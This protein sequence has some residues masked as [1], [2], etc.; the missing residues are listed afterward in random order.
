VVNWLRLRDPGFS[1]LRRACRSAILMPLLFAVGLHLLG[2]TQVAVFAAF[3]ALA[4]MML[5][6]FTGPMHERLQS[7]AGLAAGGAVMITLGTLTSADAWVAAAAML[8]VGFA[9]L[10]AGCVSSVLV[11]ASFALLL[12]FILPVCLPG[13]AGDIPARLGGWGM[14][15]AVAMVAIAVLWPAPENALLRDRVRRTCEA[16]AEC[17]ESEAAHLRDGPASASEAQR[18]ASFDR[19]GAAVSELQSFFLAT[20]TRPTDLTTQGRLLVRMVDE[21]AWLGAVLRTDQEPPSGGVADTV[22]AV[23]SAAAVV[24]ARSASLLAE[25]G[26]ATGELAAALGTLDA[27]QRQLEHAVL[28]E[29]PH[30]PRANR[31]TTALAPSFRTREVGYA[32]SLVG[33]NVTGVLL[34]ERRSWWE[35]LLGREPDG[36]LTPWGAARERAA[37]HWRRRSVW[38]HNSLRG[39]IA[40]ALAVWVANESGLQH[41]FWVVLGTLSVL[42]SNA[43]NTGQLVIR[44]IAG[45]ILGFVVGAVILIGVGTDTRALWAVLPVAVLGAGLAPAAIS[46]AAGQAGFTVTLVVLFNI[47]EPAGWKVGLVR[48]EDVAIGCAISLLVGLLFWPRGAAAALRQALADAYAVCAGY[49]DEAVECGLQ[50][51]AEHLPRPADGAGRAR[52]A[53]AARRLDDAFRTYLCERA[54]KPVPVAAVARLVSGVTALRV[55]GGALRELWRGG[56]A[57]PPGAAAA[58]DELRR[59]S[60]VLRDWYGALAQGISGPAAVPKPLDGDDAAA[61]RLVEA[62]HRQF[63]GNPSPDAPA[64]VHLIWTAD[65]LDALRRLQ[66]LLV[67]PARRASGVR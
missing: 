27:A 39:A 51:P 4:T 63:G 9:V 56:H 57:V 50:P 53:A 49:V 1:A 29:F 22:A 17:L 41:A 40:L 36:V 37:A 31:L 15:A 11:S 60:H 26:A 7:M 10:F 16:L 48:V 44:G 19:V 32:A 35:R 20:S 3:G 33:R 65:H 67:D 58:R 28:R 13:S 43:L 8:V 14:S 38:M 45:T 5:V 18:K 64:V 24:L 2:S 59:A 55:N 52:A 66:V 30:T 54:A 62:L 42:R 12:T 6:D 61:A 25:R 23:R 47:L 21:L 46:F 34:A